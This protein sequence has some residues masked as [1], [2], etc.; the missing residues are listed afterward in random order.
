MTI[1]NLSHDGWSDHQLPEG[2][3]VFL[4][5][6]AHFVPEIS[7]AEKA[8]SALGFQLTPLTPQTYATGQG[9]P[10]VKVG[11]ANRCALLERG[12]L[13]ILTPYGKAETPMAEQLSTALE[14]YIGV[15]L[16]A[17]SCVDPKAQE[18]RLATHG[19]EPQAPVPLQ[20]E[21]QTEIGPAMLRFSVLRV[22]PNTM[23]EGRIQFVRHHTPELLWQ[24]RW[25]SHP[26]GA[27]ALTDI[28]LCVDDP[29]EVAS[30]FANFT[31]IRSG[32]EPIR[33]VTARGRLTFLNVDAAA[34]LLPKLP[35]IRRPFI[36]AYAVTSANV[37]QARQH[38]LAH[39]LH[40][41]DFDPDTGSFWVNG[42]QGLGSV[43]L[44]HENTETCPWHKPP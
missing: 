36:A 18:I 6:L 2:E 25:M 34:R 8:M 7:V 27:R 37:E 17:F 5:H 19:F 3:E 30:R 44:F 16:L 40:P 23:A 39:G 29:L 24:E 12:Y 22:K 32:G 43:I 28:M 31:G 38:V 21:T 14:R 10:P 4:D 42:P 9:E 26:N 15:H 41:Y 1:Q 20:R 13:E 11:L 33:I 35:D